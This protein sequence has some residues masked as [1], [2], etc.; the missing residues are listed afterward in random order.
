M[1]NISFT[2]LSSFFGFLI[3]VI[4]KEIEFRQYTW[5]IYFDILK[6]ELKKFKLIQIVD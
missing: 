5:N 1:I 2:K 3:L 6:V 4:I